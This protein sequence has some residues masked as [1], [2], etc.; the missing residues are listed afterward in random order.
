MGYLKD[1]VLN[2]IFKNFKVSCVNVA[3]RTVIDDSYFLS[4]FKKIRREKRIAQ[5]FWE[6]FNIYR[7]VQQTR[8]VKGDVVEVGVYRGGSAKLIAELKGGKS[9]YLFDTF[10]GIPQ[11]SRI[12]KHRSGDF[13]ETSHEDVE[14]YLKNYKNIFVVKGVFPDSA[15]MIR[16]KKFSFVHLD[17]DMY[18]STLDSLGFLYN[19]MSEGGV[20]LS[21]DYNS[22][23]CPGVKKA[24]DEF[25]SN[26][27]EPVVELSATSQCLVIKQ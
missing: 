19:K 24:F 23:S 13:K 10:E 15:N 6:L 17:V 4:L 5:S 12:D 26:K 25:F 20:I 2:F 7:L 22:K 8:K 16:D 3:N 9:L 11:K 14:R 27:K 18:K 1:L 21:H